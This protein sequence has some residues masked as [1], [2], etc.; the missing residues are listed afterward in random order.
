MG[1]G[2]PVSVV[3]ASTR[4]MPGTAWQA[5]LRAR[6][7]AAY[8]LRLYLP[9]SRLAAH[10]RDR[11]RRWRGH[12][13]AASRRRLPGLAWS[14]FVARRPVLLVEPEKRDGNVSMSELAVLAQIA[15]AVP[16]GSDIIEI[17]TFD[18]RT[19]LNLAVNSRR[20]VSIFT[21]DLPGGADTALAVETSERRY[22]DKPQP[23]ARLRDC[24]APWWVYAD[25][26]IQLIG[27]SATFD[28]LAYFG[29]AGLV[30][31]DGAHS[32]DYVRKDSETALALV[33]PEGVVIWH[34]YGVWPGVTSALEELERERGLDL[35]HI[36]GTS[37]VVWRAPAVNLVPE[38]G[39]G[40][41]PGDGLELAPTEMPADFG[42]LSALD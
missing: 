11:A 40:H 42:K 12:S 41:L 15:A 34:D 9:A 33:R 20:A 37:L 1:W 22:I 3:V 38:P 21:L 13:A 16:A 36:R 18:G 2:L 7:S 4:D 24:A 19:T 30:F 35:R 26:V 5:L 8:A 39:A 27:D 29:R 32:Y 6:L 14:Q 10:L 31:V 28:W 23:G 25:R 17:G